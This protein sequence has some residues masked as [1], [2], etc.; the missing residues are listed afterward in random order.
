M[1]IAEQVLGRLVVS[2]NLAIRLFE[3]AMPPVR[4]T[5]GLPWDGELLASWEAIREE[6]DRFVASG[7]RL[8]L[9]DEVI[10]EHQGNDGPWRA[11]LLLAKGRPCGISKRFPV[12]VAA[13]RRIPGLRSALWSVLDAGTELPEH[14]GPN[15]GVLRYHLGVD[16]GRSSAL[17]V[18]ELV[19]PYSD[20]RSVLF[21]D[22]VL[23]A[24]WNH[25]EL[26]RV[27]LFCEIERPLPTMLKWR[28]RAVQSVISLDGRYRLAPRR[29]AALEQ[30]LNKGIDGTH[31]TLPNSSPSD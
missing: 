27:T 21:D 5:D 26:S 12:T 16:C 25:G 8:P 2:N 10:G 11:G 31:V 6:W 22:T 29:A 18:G 4:L 30:R 1:S 28:N 3:G 9:I 15:A 7:G 14:N 19:V 17:R 23:H 13:L 20:G 24:A